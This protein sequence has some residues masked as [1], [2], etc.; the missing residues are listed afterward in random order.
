MLE[1]GCLTQRLGRSAT[2]P[3]NP[4]QVSAVTMVCSCKFLGNQGED[5]FEQAKFR[6]PDRKLCRVHSHRQSS[7]T[8]IGVVANQR[9][10]SALVPLPTSVQSERA[11]GDHEPAFQ[12]RLN[13]DHH[14]PRS[15]SACCGWFLLG[16][17]NPRSTSPFPP[18]ALVFSRKAPALHRYFRDTPFPVPPR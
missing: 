18:R 11:S 12:R 13:R 8:G 9:A 14:G 7:G 5:R 17:S 10:L 2:N 6:P 3:A 16:A 4:R 1:Q 15:V